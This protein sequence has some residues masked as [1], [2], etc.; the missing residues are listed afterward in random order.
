L[1]VAVWVAGT[2]GLRL[3]FAEEDPDDVVALGV[4]RLV[5]RICQVP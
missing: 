1:R 4:V 5:A 2:S 3:G